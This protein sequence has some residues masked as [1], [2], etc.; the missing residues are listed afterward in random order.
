MRVRNPTDILK[1]A[2]LLQ[3]LSIY[4]TKEMSKC[5]IAKIIQKTI[6]RKFNSNYE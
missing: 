3:P 2:G 5:Q 4:N 1:K 6:V